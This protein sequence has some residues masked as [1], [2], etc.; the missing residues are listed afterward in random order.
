M[1]EACSSESQTEKY[2]REMKGAIWAD[3]SSPGNSCTQTTRVCASF[4]CTRPVIDTFLS[5]HAR[6]SAGGFPLL[7]L[8]V[9]TES[10]NNPTLVC[11]FLKTCE[12]LG[13][14]DAVLLEH[15]RYVGQLVL[16]RTRDHE[17]GI[18]QREALHAVAP[19]LWGR[20]SDRGDGATHVFHSRTNAGGRDES[21]TEGRASGSAEESSLQASFLFHR[22]P[23]NSIDHLHLHCLAEPGR[24][25]LL[26]F[27]KYEKL[28]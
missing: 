10:Q 27:A 1:R 20:R 9:L 15:M 17:Q 12:D 25:R 2:Y 18:G 13:P 5:C 11:R 4:P 23:F 24:R 3:D 26:D 28:G 22:P 19:E 7:F 8:F 6:S 14:Q 16:D 21:R